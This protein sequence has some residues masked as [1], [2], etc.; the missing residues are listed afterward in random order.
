MPWSSRV[1]NQES[2]VL[3]LVLIS[4]CS[5]W[6]WHY[7]ARAW[8]HVFNTT[9]KGQLNNSLYIL[10]VIRDPLHILTNSILSLSLLGS[11]HTLLRTDA[12]LGSL[13]IWTD[14]HD[15]IHHKSKAKHN[16]LRKRRVRPETSGLESAKANY[17]MTAAVLT[18]VDFILAILCWLKTW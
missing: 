10:Q 3:H 8:L 17:W 16:S 1:P 7:H 6:M 14:K 11:F 4:V 9:F 2:K 5:L 13:L 12:A 15:F 18:L